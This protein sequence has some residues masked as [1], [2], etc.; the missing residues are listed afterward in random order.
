MSKDGTGNYGVANHMG[1]VF[2][3]NGTETHDGL[4]VCDGAIVPAAVGVNPFATITAL[5]ER[6]VELVAQK[7]GITID[8]D[9]K[10]GKS[11][12]RSTCP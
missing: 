12:E 3:G 4:I 2:T 1:E 9:M 7:R 10:N 5:A 8:Y 11:H 6:S